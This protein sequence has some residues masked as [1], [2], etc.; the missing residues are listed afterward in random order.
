MEVSLVRGRARIL[1][2]LNTEPALPAASRLPNRQQE[3]WSRSGAGACS[4]AVAP[5]CL[6]CLPAEPDALLLV[7]PC[8]APPLPTS[9]ALLEGSLREERQA[10]CVLGLGTGDLSNSAPL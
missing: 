2:V 3:T 10:H 9:R 7:A 1:D 6:P 5:P 8:Y 4:K